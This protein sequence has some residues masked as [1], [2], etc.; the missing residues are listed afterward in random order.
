[1]ISRAEGKTGGEALKIISGHAI[2]VHN[3]RSED[4]YQQDI[5]TAFFMPAIGKMTSTYYDEKP[6]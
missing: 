2:N 6:Y 3:M 5:S 4:I 1:V